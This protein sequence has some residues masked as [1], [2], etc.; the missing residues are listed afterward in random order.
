VAVHQL[1]VNPG[2]FA[3]SA[4]GSIEFR[5]VLNGMGK[6]VAFALV[7][8]I[9]CCFQGYFAGVGAR[10]VGQAIN[11]AIVGVCIICIVINYFLSELMYG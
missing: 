7:I 2:V 3:A 11:R 1:H 8:S 5:D 4:L 6:G 10:G 9:F